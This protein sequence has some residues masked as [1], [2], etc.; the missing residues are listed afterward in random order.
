MADLYPSAFVHENTAAAIYFAFNSKLDDPT[1]DSKILFINI[2]SLG[3]KLS[4]VRVKNAYD[5]P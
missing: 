2:G 4:I 1:Y 5:D 3:T